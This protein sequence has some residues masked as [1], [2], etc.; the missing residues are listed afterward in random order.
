MIYIFECPRCTR[1]QYDEVDE[2]L[3]EGQDVICE[4][5][6]E[7]VPVTILPDTPNADAYQEWCSVHEREP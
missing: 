5:C 7:I 2:N 3:G 6:G 1:R 4:E